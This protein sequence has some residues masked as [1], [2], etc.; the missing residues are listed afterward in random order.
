MKKKDFVK[1]VKPLIKECIKEMIM[2]EN[3]LSNVISETILAI[4]NVE[5][6]SENKSKKI[7][8]IPNKKVKNLS[9][10]SKDMYN[11]VD[12]FDG[13]TPSKEINE[14]LSDTSG[15][16]ASKRFPGLDFNDSGVDISM[17]F[18]N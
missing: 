2:E 1:L 18:K 15:V 14:S 13:V 5:V 7:S 11:G 12:V 16:S 3:L 9:N 17:F 8:Q 6:I 10:L 4:N